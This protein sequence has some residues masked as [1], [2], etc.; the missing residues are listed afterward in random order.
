MDWKPRLRPPLSLIAA[1]LFGQAVITA[2]VVAVLTMVNAPG[3][4]PPAGVRQLP[5]EAVPRYY[6][7]LTGSPASRLQ[8]TDIIIRDTVSG[9]ALATVRPPAPYP[10]FTM[11]AATASASAWIVA[12]SL[13]TAP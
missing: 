8:A 13:I 6:A 4:P 7:A 1:A 10:A 12:A 11:V 9:T 5:R 2:A 3:A